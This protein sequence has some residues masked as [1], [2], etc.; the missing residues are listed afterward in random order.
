[1]TENSTHVSCPRTRRNAAATPW[2]VQRRYRRCPRRSEVIV[3][4]EVLAGIRWQLFFLSLPYGP[5]LLVLKLV[6]VNG[7]TSVHGQHIGNSPV[8]LRALL[9]QRG[10]GATS[11]TIGWQKP[12]RYLHHEKL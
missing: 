4:Q 10:S 9:E 8:V 7:R 5:H 11:K 2:F 1:M 3:L 6:G 12:A